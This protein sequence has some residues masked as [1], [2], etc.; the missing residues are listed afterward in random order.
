MTSQSLKTNAVGHPDL[1]R[2][3]LNQEGRRLTH[4]RKKILTLFENSAAKKHLSAEEIRQQLIHQGEKVSFSTIY[5]T[6]HVMIEMGLL[7][8]VG[9]VEGRRYYELSNPFSKEHHHL[10]CVQ[11]GAIQEFDDHQVMVAAQKET[12]NR[13]FSLSNCQFTVFGVCPKCQLE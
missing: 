5:R 11:C 2:S 4:Q 10:V 7:Q 6:L 3:I 12:K 1:L 9:P 13:G 8:E